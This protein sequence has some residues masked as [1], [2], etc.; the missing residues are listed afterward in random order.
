MRSMCKM[1]ILRRIRELGGSREDLLLVYKLQIRCVTELACPAWN[2]ALTVKDTIKL[3]NIQ[4]CAVRIILGS[5]FTSYSAALVTLNIMSLKSRRRSLCLSFATKTAT[6]PKYSA[7]FKKIDRNTRSGLKIGNGKEK[8]KKITKYFVPVT[9][10]TRYQ[11][12]P[13]LYLANLLNCDPVNS[14]H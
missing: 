1:W 5:S 7:C 14:I 13:L 4:K 12:S 3:E 9:R 10:T 8:D 6:N 11:K 2:G